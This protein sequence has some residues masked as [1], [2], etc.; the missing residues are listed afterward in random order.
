M[1]AENPICKHCG[2]EKI[3]CQ[4]EGWTCLNEKCPQYLSIVT[5]DTMTLPEEVAKETLCYFK[6]KGK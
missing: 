1:Y 6:I 4:G 5:I 2:E 3:N